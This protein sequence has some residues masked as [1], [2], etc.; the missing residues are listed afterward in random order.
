MIFPESNASC[1]FQ[2]QCTGN[3]TVVTD[4]PPLLRAAREELKKRSPTA[5][6]GKVL[7]IG[8]RQGLSAQGGM[9]FS[10]TSQLAVKPGVPLTLLP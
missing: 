9:A 7:H 8:S 6:V 2:G 5:D 4:L 1:L 3:T 10:L